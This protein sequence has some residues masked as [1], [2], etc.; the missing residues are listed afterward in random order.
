MVNFYLASSNAHLAL[1][2]TF[3]ATSTCK[4]V[5]VSSLNQQMSH[6]LKALLQYNRELHD[7]HVTLRRRILDVLRIHRES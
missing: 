1:R 7:A 4:T 2:C 6:E 3:H 5:Y